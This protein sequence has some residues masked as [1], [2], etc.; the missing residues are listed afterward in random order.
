MRY[1]GER[2]RRPKGMGRTMTERTDASSLKEENRRLRR[3]IELW[4]STVVEP[5]R[6]VLRERIAN[7]LDDEAATAGDE[8]DAPKNRRQG[9]KRSVVASAGV[10]TRRT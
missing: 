6:T 4:Q 1:S 3:E 10:L 8:Q 9:R 7:V 5:W 2:P